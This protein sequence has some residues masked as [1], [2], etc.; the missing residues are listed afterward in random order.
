MQESQKAKI[1]KELVK[2]PDFE[3]IYKV[4]KTIP[5]YRDILKELA[6]TYQIYYNPKDQRF[7]TDTSDHSHYLDCRYDDVKECIMTL[8][9]ENL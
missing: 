3:S 2:A 9:D 5:S 6:H 4:L 8:I 1:A 7:E